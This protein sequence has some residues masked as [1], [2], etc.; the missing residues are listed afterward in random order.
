MMMRFMCD[1]FVVR[2]ILL[3][4]CAVAI[5]ARAQVDPLEDGV[6]AAPK[7]TTAPATR[8]SSTQ[9]ATTQPVPGKLVL[10]TWL[11]NGF[12][13]N[14]V[15]LSFDRQGR[16]YVAETQRREGGEFQTR[17]DPAHRVLP[18]HTFLTVADRSRWAGDGDA[19]WGEQIGGK[20]ETIHIVEDSH[21]TGKADKAAIYYEGFNHNDCDVLCGVLWNE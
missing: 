12:L 7:T 9:P 21:R 14:P 17:T 10:T 3:V 11:P 18:D 1:G 13:K 5:D 6:P 20:K 8:E 2:L 4:I 15:A 16:A 19:A